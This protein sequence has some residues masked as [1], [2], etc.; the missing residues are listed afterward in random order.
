LSTLLNYSKRKTIGRQNDFV[1]VVG[2]LVTSGKSL[3]QSARF[4]AKIS[5]SVEA[6]GTCSC[7]ASSSPLI[8]RCQLGVCFRLR[9]ASPFDGTLVSYC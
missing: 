6:R 2:K 9:F 7:P 8:G 5:K 1:K 4:R 3:L